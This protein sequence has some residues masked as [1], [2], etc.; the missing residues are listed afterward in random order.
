MIERAGRTRL[1]IEARRRSSSFA[2]AAEYLDR[3]VASEALVAGTV[4][5]AHRA[6]ADQAG[7]L[8]SGRDGCRWRDS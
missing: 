6:L 8:R 5:L 3:H 2:K 4:D 1:V 7:D